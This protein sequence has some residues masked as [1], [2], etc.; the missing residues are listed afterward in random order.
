MRNK[1]NILY[2]ATL[3]GHVTTNR[4]RRGIYFVV[5]NL[6]RELLKCNDVN[7]IVYYHPDLV[8][9][10][11]YFKEQ[12]KELY[13]EE[14][15][16]IAN[17]KG[18]LFNQSEVDVVLN[19]WLWMPE[20]LNNIHVSKF[21]FVY[22]MMAYLQ[23]GYEDFLQPGGWFQ[24]VCASINSDNFIITDSRSARDD[25]LKLNPSL[26]KNQIGVSYLAADPTK[27]Y[28]VSRS[29]REHFLARIGLNS[30]DKFIFALCAIESRKNLVTNIHAFVKFV[31]KYNIENLYFI[32]GG[33]N[34]DAFAKTLDGYI[35]KSPI[36]M[37]YIKRVGYVPDKD[38][39]FYY[40][41]SEWFVFA[42]QYE[43]F[44]LPALEAMMCGTPVIASNTTS[45]P[46]VCSNSA[47]LVAPTSLDSH[48]KAFET[49]WF[50]ESIRELYK[51]KSLLNSAKYSWSKTAENIVTFIR[52]N[53]NDRQFAPLEH[54][55]S[56]MGIY[57]VDQ[58]GERHVKGSRVKCYFKYLY[59]S[60]LC[61]LSR[62]N[63]K[64]RLARKKSLYKNLSKSR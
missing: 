7:V 15:P 6:L 30:T 2:D 41:F 56:E 17:E 59:Y 43:G 5:V 9:S 18:N 61:R 53:Y 24:K 28:Q 23:P 38:L 34:W 49:L 63:V 40:S 12:I 19:T 16:L 60:L 29:E 39:P 46:E 1:L 21:L 55:R 26:R 51:Q 33:A 62:G 44:G 8:S 35:S 4:T 57:R 42:S 3:I 11:E 50:D 45:L 52:E 48:V 10:L 64:Q 14:C 27:F 54:V 20:F 37:K 13:P 47:I 25:I 32:I 31:E 36:L 22:D 58:I